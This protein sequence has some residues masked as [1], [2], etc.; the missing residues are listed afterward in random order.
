MKRNIYNKYITIAICIINII[1][2]CSLFF[3]L[4]RRQSGQ[5]VQHWCTHRG[6]ECSTFGPGAAFAL[7]TPDTGLG[8]W[9]ARKPSGTLQHQCPCRGSKW[10]WAALRAVEIRGQCPGG[11]SHWQQRVAHQGHRCRSGCQ[12]ET[13][14][15]L[16]NETQWQFAIDSKSGLITTVG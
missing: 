4:N 12:C 9:S 14:L 15:L 7:Y 11:C 16:A 6:V 1:L 8:S 3:L 10:Q 2:N 5:Q 13:R